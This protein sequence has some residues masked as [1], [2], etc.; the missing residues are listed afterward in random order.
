MKNCF[1]WIAFNDQTLKR[2]K[3]EP[4]T[5]KKKIGDAEEDKYVLCSTLTPIHRKSQKTQKSIT[6]TNR[7][8]KNS[9][10]TFETGRFEQHTSTINDR[11]QQKQ[12]VKIDVN[13]ITLPNATRAYGEFE[14]KNKEQQSSEWQVSLCAH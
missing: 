7:L 1:C 12:G 6:D 11:K 8:Q 13:A 4:N 10:K 9:S 2:Q 14:N 5:D 3:I